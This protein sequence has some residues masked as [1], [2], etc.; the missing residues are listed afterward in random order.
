MEDYE[1]ET[2]EFRSQLLRPF[3]G[4]L[5]LNELAIKDLSTFFNHLALSFL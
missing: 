1:G 5:C 3:Y 4:L 2:I